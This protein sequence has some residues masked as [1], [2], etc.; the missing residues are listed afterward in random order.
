MAIPFCFGLLVGACVGA[1]V[2]VG[3]VVGAVSMFARFEVEG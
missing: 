2:V 1:A 3:I